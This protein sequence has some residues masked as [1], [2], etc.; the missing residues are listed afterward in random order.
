M[1]GTLTATGNTILRGTVDAF[2]RV[3]VSG[4]LFVTG[5]KV[6][7]SAGDLAE[8]SF[9]VANNQAAAAN[10]TGLAFANGTV[11]GFTALVSVFVNATTPLYGVYVL[12]GVQK[13]SGWSMTSQFAGDDTRIAFTITSAGQIQYTTPT[14]AG[15][16]AATLKFRAQTVSV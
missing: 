14:Y 6:T 10:I 4:D 12:T 5:V 11:R 9:S 3:N 2:S 15:F 16:T 1:F 8:A 7:P 13:A